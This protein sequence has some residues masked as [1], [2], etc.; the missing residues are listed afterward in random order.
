MISRRELGKSYAETTTAS[1]V[2]MATILRV[3]SMVASL[4]LMLP[5]YA[6]VPVTPYDLNHTA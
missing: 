5:I 6:T 2:P 3:E 4:G 1:T